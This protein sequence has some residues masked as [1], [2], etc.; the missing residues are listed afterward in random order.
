MPA[1]LE[2]MDTDE[3]CINAVW[4]VAPM[5]SAPPGVMFSAPVLVIS[6]PFT[7]RSPAVVM[8]P[9]AS[10]WKASPVP[11]N[12][13][14]AMSALTLT[15]RLPVTLVAPCSSMASALLKMMSLPAPLEVMVVIAPCRVAF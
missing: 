2:V 12:S 1:P 9:F 7:A 13:V 3:P 8:L 10:T 11:T 14:P 4:F 6:P 5:V 15:V